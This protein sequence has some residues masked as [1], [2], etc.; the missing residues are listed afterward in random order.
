MYDPRASVM[1]GIRVQ[2]L[3]K[4]AIGPFSPYVF[5]GKTKLENEEEIGN[6]RML[7][8]NETKVKRDPS[9]S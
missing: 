5:H 6:R 7:L 8:T 3:V 1:W 9:Y 4:G 2:C